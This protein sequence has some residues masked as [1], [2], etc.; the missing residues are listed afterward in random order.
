MNLLSLEYFIA[1]AR[2]GSISKAAG[3]L[4]VSQQTLSEHLGK[5]EREL[6]ATLFERKRPMELT[7]AG[8]RLLSGARDIIQTRELVMQ[9]IANINNNTA[10]KIFI[11]LT[12]SYISPFLSKFLTNFAAK[13]SHYKII[14]SN[15]TAEE[16][17]NSADINIFFVDTDLI[18]NPHIEIEVL[19]PDE[20]YSVVIHQAL[21][22]KT[23]GDYWHTVEKA[24]LDTQDLSLL[25][26]LPFIMTRD[27]NGQNSPMLVNAFKQA[28]LRPTLRYYSEIENLN[29]DICVSG[30][31]AYLGPESFCRSQFDSFLEQ[32]DF[33]KLYSIRLPQH[34]P[35]VLFCY[36]NTKPLSEAEMTFIDTVRQHT[37]TY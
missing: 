10:G 34:T 30:C 25:H 21:W 18:N 12:S 19:N 36:K 15:V 9:D 6:H 3:E 22:E 37:I 31:G 13:H 11:G 5:L 7:H 28:G 20:H 32:S 16:A 26:G 35:R 24:L 8:R 14:L 2:Y 33:L 29:I 23:Y 17:M 1:I 27:H 4:Y